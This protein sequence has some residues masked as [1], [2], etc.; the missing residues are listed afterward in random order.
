M[1]QIQSQNTRRINTVNNIYIT[2]ANTKGTS[3]GRCTHYN[4]AKFRFALKY[5]HTTSILTVH[6]FKK[7]VNNSFKEF[8]MRSASTEIKCGTG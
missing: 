1:A 5:I 3:I 6:E 8:P 7:F 2:S 4:Y